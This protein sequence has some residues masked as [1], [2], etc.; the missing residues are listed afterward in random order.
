MPLLKKEEEVKPV[1][2]QKLVAEVKEETKPIA[3]K[4]EEVDPVITKKPITQREE[5][6]QAETIPP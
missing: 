3:K 4:E 6:P 2:E 5:L 1:V